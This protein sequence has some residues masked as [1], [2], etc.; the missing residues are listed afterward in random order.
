[1][2]AVENHPLAISESIVLNAKSGLNAISR[3]SLDTKHHTTTNLEI[4]KSSLADHLQIVAILHASIKTTL[5]KLCFFMYQPAFFR[6]RRSIDN[7]WH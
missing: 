1:M 3:I 6:W 2:N 4:C 5:H 7:P